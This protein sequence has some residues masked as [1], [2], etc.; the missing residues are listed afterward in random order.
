MAQYE[1]TT[2]PKTT[3]PNILVTTGAYKIVTT[4]PTAGDI[5][6][7]RWERGAII[8]LLS[9]GTLDVQISIRKSNDE[10]GNS[11]EPDVIMTSLGT[12]SVIPMLEEYRMLEGEYKNQ[13]V[14]DVLTTGDS[15][16][17]SGIF[18]I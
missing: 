1:L 11:R 4:P 6:F 5:L 12:T 17:Y 7:G 16:L 9:L 18:W 8:A 3:G 2:V 15:A 14:I 13:F 10:N